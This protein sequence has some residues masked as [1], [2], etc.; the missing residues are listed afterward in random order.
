[1][2][3]ALYISTTNTAMAGGDGKDKKA[4]PQEYKFAA[5]PE[6]KTGWEG[7]RQFLWNSET[8]EFLGRTGLSWLKIGV[9]Y[10]IYYALLAGFFMGMLFIF[11]QTLDDHSPR[12]QNSNGIIG[13]NPGVGFR[14]Q[15]HDDDIESTLVWFRHGEDNPSW[16]P[17]VDRLEKFLEPYKKEEEK[18]KAG[19]KIVRV[20]CGYQASNRAGDKQICKINSEELF[21]GDCTKDKAYGYREGKPCILL[22]LNKIFG[23][24]PDYY[25]ISD[26]DKPVPETVP[27]ALRD[28]MKE[29]EEKGT[30]ELNKR[31]W[32]ECK[33]E[34]PADVENAGSIKYYPDQGFSA[35]YFPY[36]NQPGYL[37][38]AVFIQLE[39]PTKGVMIA[40]ECKAWAD[41]IKHDAME[42]R[43]LAHFEV[44]ID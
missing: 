4:E 10:V 18:T 33:G 23:W 7:F 41:N 8:S 17:W 40:I 11:Y 9:F 38:P 14:P 43:G 20:D 39:N 13:S 44:M 12:W 31:V 16:K 26:T 28:K 25:N 3:S 22:K 19:D 29:N 15:P 5:K 37:S 6:E 35:N 32:L 2:G 42:R 34:N 24:L 21:Q 30:P 27:Q 36:K 1:M